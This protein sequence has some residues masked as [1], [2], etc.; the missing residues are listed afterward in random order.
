MTSTE[1]SRRRRARLAEGHDPRVTIDELRAM[2]V[3]DVTRVAACPVCG[4]WHEGKRDN[5]CFEEISQGASCEIRGAA[6]TKKALRITRT[7][8]EARQGQK[9]TLSGK[10]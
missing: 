10:P 4:T 7:S 2:T 8:T 9:F 1:R 3:K 6:M 5:L